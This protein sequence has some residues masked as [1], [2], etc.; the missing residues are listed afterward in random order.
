[1]WGGGAADLKS[2]SYEC[3]QERHFLEERL[4]T[5]Y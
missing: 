5:G 2:M 3:I 4:T 1:M